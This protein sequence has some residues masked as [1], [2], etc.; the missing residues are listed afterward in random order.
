[1]RWHAGPFYYTIISEVRPM[2]VYYN[3]HPRGRKTG[4]CV[5]RAICAVTGKTW[6][7]VYTGVALLGYAMEDMPS[8]NNVWREYLRS[9]GYK[10]RAIPDSCPDCYTVGD[11]AREHQT[12][13]YVLGTGT[14]AVAVTDGGVIRDTWDSSGEPV[15]YYYFKEATT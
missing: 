3:P 8:N 9:L 13:N 14:H 11:F 4:D 6:D 10:R 12:G 1:M 15:F 7:E 5:I 2:W